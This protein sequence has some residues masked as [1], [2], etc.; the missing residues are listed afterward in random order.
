MNETELNRRECL[1]LLASTTFGQLAFTRDALPAVVPARYIV[2]PEQILIHA[3]PA[4]ADARW[5]GGEVV[6]LHASAFDDHQRYG[7]TVTVTGVGHRA[8]ELRDA[9]AAPS[10]PWIAPGDGD[11]I[12][13]EV[14]LVCGERLGPPRDAKRT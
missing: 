9:Y 5:K 14:G 3:T 10:A 12:A 6:A 8:G 11:L 7:W 1:A 2:Y 4:L 13:L